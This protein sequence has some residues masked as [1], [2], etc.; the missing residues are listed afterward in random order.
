MEGE[1]QEAVGMNVRRL[2]AELG[3]SQESFGQSI[4]WHRTF[5]GAV[6]RGERNLTL[7]TVERLAQQLGVHPLDLLL[8]PERVSVLRTEEGAPRFV[9]RPTLR[10]ADRALGSSGRPVPPGSARD[11]PPVRRPRPS[12]A[13]PA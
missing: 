12:G 8:D 9:D 2:R 1:L 11:Q 5:V 10:A 3:Y 6:E 4:G 7:R 13:D